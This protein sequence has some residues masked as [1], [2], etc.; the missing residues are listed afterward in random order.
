MVLIDSED[1]RLVTSLPE[2]PLAISEDFY[3]IGLD[4]RTG[5]PRLHAKAM[6]LGTSAALLAELVLADQIAC[7]DDRIIVA[8]RLQL[9][10]D[11][12]LANML[13]HIVAE[14]QHS[15]STWLTYFA[16]TSVDGVI[17]RLLATGFLR[18]ET[19]RGLLRSKPAYVPTDPISLSWRS[20]RIAHVIS[21]RD[22]RTWED[23]TLVG[24]VVATG[25]LE[26]VLYNAS[27][28]D[29]ESLRYILG[30]LP[31]EVSLHALI[32]QVEALIAASVL[33]QRK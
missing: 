30:R 3:L 17:G 32:T 25:L 33:S 13:R 15:V 1:R 18:A 10:A 31:E 9:P 14:P 29:I 2:A 22:L 16:R 24:L 26:S 23:L 27:P 7:L 11:P 5:R 12:L 21:K 20:L 19:S 6:S 28:E 8:P 4:E